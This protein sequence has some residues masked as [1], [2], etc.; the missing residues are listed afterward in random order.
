MTDDSPTGAAAMPPADARPAHVAIIMDGNGRWAQACGQPRLYGH[1]QGANVVREITTFS[2]ELGIDYL[3]LYSFSV[4]N[5]RRPLAEVTGLMHLLEEYCV[6]E[7][8]T[9]MD[10]GVRLATIGDLG[11]LPPSTQLALAQLQEETAVN[12]EMVLT[13]ALS[14]GGREEIVRAAQRLAA[15][16]VAGELEPEAIDEALLAAKL[17]TN[18]LPDPDLVIRTSGELRL[19]NFLLWQVAYA[20]FVFVDV[21]WPEFTRAHFA[22]ALH[23]YARRSRRFGA[24][25]GQAALC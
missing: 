21:H 12:D 15:A 13:L 11:R 5:W 3:T 4:Q 14:Y 20:E 19:S 2:R 17:Y 10:N 24:T 7:R 25:G 1:R 18:G 6:E 16:A 9:L 22:G 23:E 8:D